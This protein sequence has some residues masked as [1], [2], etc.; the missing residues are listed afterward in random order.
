MNAKKLISLCGMMVFGGLVTVSGCNGMK[1]G[2]GDEENGVTASVKMAFSG[3]GVSWYGNSVLID[4]E[5]D[6]NAD[7][8]Y[9]CF[10]HATACFNFNAD[11]TLKP[12]PNNEEDA[13]KFNELC[14]S[15]AVNQPVPPGVDPG[16]GT[17]DFYYYVHVGK[18]CVGEELTNNDHDFACY[19]P[20]NLLARENANSTLNEEL[21]GGAEVVNQV[22][23]LSDN[24][25]KDFEFFSCADVDVPYGAY[26]DIA[27]DCG[28]VVDPYTYDCDCGFDPGVFG[29]CNATPAH[30]CVILCDAP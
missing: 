22:F 8:K 5:R 16:D 14:A 26:A 13:A 4:A 1:P 3:S 10:N 23:C 20:E 7:S 19:A 18:N 27:L 24:V 25:D 15:N 6:G 12:A 28:C 21:P 11:G 30:Q 29:D 2:S 9:R 17:Y